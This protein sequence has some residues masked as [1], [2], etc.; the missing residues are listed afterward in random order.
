MMHSA[1]YALTGGKI[2]TMAGRVIENGAVLIREGKIE[3]AGTD[4]KIPENAEVINVC[5]K[6]V[7]PGFIDAHSHISAINE[8]QYIGGVDDDNEMTDPITPF[9]RGYDSFNPFEISIGNVRSAG[10]TSA[11]TLPGSANIIGGTGFAFKLKKANSVDK[12]AIPGTEC[13]KMALGE[14]PRMCYGNMKKRMPSTR[15]GTAALLRE[16]LSKAKDY[17]RAIEDGKDQ[18]FDPSLS[19]LVPV[20]RGEMKVRIHCH[21]ADDIVTACRVSTEFGLDFSIEHCTEGY[22]IIDVLK[23]YDPYCVIGPLMM[24]PIK[25]EM[26]GINIE[27]AGILANAGLRIC[28]TADSASPTMFLPYQIG[29]CMARSNLSFEQALKA[30]T[31]TPAELTGII[32]RTGT[33]EKGKDA[34]LAVFSGEPFITGTLCEKTVIEGEIYENAE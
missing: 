6:V 8:P 25:Q 13:M 3:D 16:T 1:L 29:Y 7:T 11:C 30:L 4:I 31:V 22:K 9:L 28:L 19:A 27:N 15:M 12:M 34:D 32:G 2:Y 10:F 23:S 26:W 33:I 5:G 18:P 21:R 17:A 24:P 20:V 14:N